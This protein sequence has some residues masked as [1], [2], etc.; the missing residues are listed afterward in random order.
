MPRSA[1]WFPLSGLTIP[2]LPYPHGNNGS[3]PPPDP[4]Q[5]QGNRR[6]PGRDERGVEALRSTLTSPSVEPR[7]ETGFEAGRDN[8]SRCQVAWANTMQCNLAWR[9]PQ[10]HAVNS[11]GDLIGS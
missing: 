11:C 5:A 6:Q 3:I 9:A 7:L 4:S 1:L 2:R 8:V 10:S